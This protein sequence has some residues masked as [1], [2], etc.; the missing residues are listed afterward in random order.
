MEKKV[1]RK[2]KNR[3]LLYLFNNNVIFMIKLLGIKRFPS[4]RHRKRLLTI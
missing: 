2:K 4:H 3:S 1:K